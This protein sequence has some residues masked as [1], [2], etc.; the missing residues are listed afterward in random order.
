MEMNTASNTGSYKDL[1]AQREALA[2]QIAQARKEE[3]G[4]A[5]AKVRDLVR[6]HELTAE[7]VFAGAKSRKA[8]TEGGGAARSTKGTKVAPKYRDPATGAEW[9]GRGKEPTW[10]KGQDR[11]AF[12]IG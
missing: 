10:I 4:A 9:T 6:Q 8:G 5:I 2:V 12:L 1:L 7:D 11:T 3:I